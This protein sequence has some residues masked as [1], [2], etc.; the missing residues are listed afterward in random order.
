MGSTT[1]VQVP[2]ADGEMPAALAA[3]AE[4]DLRLPVI[5]IHELFGFFDRYLGPAPGSSAG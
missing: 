5:V 1:A 2:L 4:P 3:P